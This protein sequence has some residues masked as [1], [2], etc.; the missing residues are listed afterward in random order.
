MKARLDSSCEEEFKEDK[1]WKNKEKADRMHFFDRFS[2]MRCQHT[3][4]WDFQR[5]SLGQFLPLYLRYMPT[6]SPFSRANQPRLYALSPACP[7]PK[8]RFE[9]KARNESN[10]RMP[11][12]EE[13]AR[14]Q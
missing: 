9:L 14:M 4:G 5:F 1:K 7:S 6:S 13:K 10:A 11:D 12:R 8:G 2:P 3:M